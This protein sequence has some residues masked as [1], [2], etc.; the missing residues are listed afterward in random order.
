MRINPDTSMGFRGLTVRQ[1]FAELIAT[2]KKSVEYRTWGCDYRGDLL[3]TTGTY[4]PKRSEDIG[5]PVQRGIAVC[6][7]RLSA[8][9]LEHPSDAELSWLLDQPRR[10]PSVPVRG[11]LGLWTVPPALVRALGL[12][13]AS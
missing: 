2:G 12:E 7:V 10:V 5:Y 11:Q 6:V 3:I 13:V 4:K 8:I 1:P 9:V